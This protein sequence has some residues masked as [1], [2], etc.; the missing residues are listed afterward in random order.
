MGCIEAL[1]ILSVAAFYLPIM[2]W[3]KGTDD[4]VADPVHFQAF[5]EKSG[6]LPVGG[7]AVGKFGP[8]IGL[9]ALD[10]TGEGLHQMIYKLSGG[11]GAVLL[12]C[13]HETPAGILVNGRV[14]EKLLSDHLGANRQTE[15]ISHQPGSAVRDNPSFHRA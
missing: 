9:D 2:P 11:I 10:R 14:L 8:I 4:L 15:Q 6:L 13:L 12:K 1:I 5:L 3:G 7:K